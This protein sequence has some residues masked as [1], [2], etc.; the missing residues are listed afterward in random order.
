MRILFSPL[1]AAGVAAAAPAARSQPGDATFCQQYADTV[2][3]ASEDAIKADPKCLNPSAGVHGD[4]N[5]HAAWCLRTPRENVEGAAV[6]IRRLANRCHSLLVVPE[7]YG[8]YSVIGH[9]Q[10]EKPYGKARDWTVSAAFSGR[11]FMYCVAERLVEG[12]Q[13]RIGVDRVMPGDSEQWQLVVPIKSGKDWP[14]QL[15]I[16][17]ADPAARAGRDIGGTHFADWTVGWLNRG[18][19]DALRKGRE[20]LVSV[21]KFDYRFSLAGIA[22]AITKVEECRERKGAVRRG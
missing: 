6:H 11:L 2:A 5:S 3:T 9:G 17:G 13:V 21:G 19:V 16:D 18:H 8:G 4:R 12:R 22:A 7:E 15:E 14:V 10:L 20:A 1:L